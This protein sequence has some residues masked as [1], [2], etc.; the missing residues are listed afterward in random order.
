MRAA[1]VP[2]TSNEHN[3]LVLGCTTSTVVCD[4]NGVVTMALR[5]L[6]DRWVEPRVSGYSVISW[7]SAVA[8]HGNGVS[9]LCPSKQSDRCE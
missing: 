6:M 4:S 1:R 9:T 3:L 5:Q 2:T 7:D 8:C